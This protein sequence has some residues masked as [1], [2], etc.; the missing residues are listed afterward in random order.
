MANP[1]AQSQLVNTYLDVIEKNNDG[2]K[3]NA[4]ATKG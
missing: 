2:K 3:N 1:T 4:A